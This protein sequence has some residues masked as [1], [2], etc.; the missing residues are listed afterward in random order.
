M[1][2]PYDG[3]VGLWHVSGG[4]VGEPTI[5]ALCQTVK[6]QCPVADAIW[7]KTSNGKYWQAEYDTKAE[8]EI[9][10]PA[11]I[12]K[13]INALNS[14]GL[15][16]HAWAVAKGTDVAAETARIVDAC[17]VPGVKSMILDV[18]ATPLGMTR[19]LMIRPR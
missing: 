12:T 5:E 13:W 18:P 14:V 16:F 6:Q 4:W 8:M 7:V 11:D 9:N 1:P 2:T 19:C 15:E 3:K 17:K 10:G